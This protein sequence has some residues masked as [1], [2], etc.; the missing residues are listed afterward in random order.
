MNI[1]RLSLDLTDRIGYRCMRN[2]FQ[3]SKRKIDKKRIDKTIF[4]AGF[5][6]IVLL[7]LADIPTEFIEHHR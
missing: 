4:V 5:F 3:R 2:F 1:D 6:P 7:N